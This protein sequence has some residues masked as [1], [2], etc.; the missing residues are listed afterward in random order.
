MEI[1]ACL[2]GEVAQEATISF[3]PSPLK[4]PFA[5]WVHCPRSAISF[6]NSKKG[7]GYTQP[8]GFGQWKIFVEP[9][10]GRVKI[11]VVKNRGIRM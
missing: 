2:N 3:N 11:Q 8:Q 10:G 4:S 6:G 9:T 7:V 1:P 5:T